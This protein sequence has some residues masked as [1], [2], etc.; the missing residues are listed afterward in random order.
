[1]TPE[2]FCYWLQGRAELQPDNL[3][4]ADEWRMIADHLRL[5][6]TKAPTVSQA[7]NPLFE[8]MERA[9]RSTQMQS[10]AG[11]IPPEFTHIC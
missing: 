6:F 1:M 3:P 10:I 4:S 11:V 7:V 5:V 9:K 2:Q 8:A